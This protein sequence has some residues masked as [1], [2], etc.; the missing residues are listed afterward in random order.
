MV[1][2]DTFPARFL[3]GGLQ[4]SRGEGDQRMHMRM[5]MRSTDDVCCLMHVAAISTGKM[6]IR[7]LEADTRLFE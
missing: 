3:Q 5:R 1:L 7:L 2:P 6:S 4:I